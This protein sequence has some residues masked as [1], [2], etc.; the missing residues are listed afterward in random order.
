VKT[1]GVTLAETIG[2]ALREDWKQSKGDACI[3]LAHDKFTV[4][5]QVK[6]MLTA[7]GDLTNP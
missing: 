7:V 2:R 5:A 1:L 3:K 4:A 6:Q